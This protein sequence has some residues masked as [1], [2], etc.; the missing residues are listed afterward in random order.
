MARPRS[1]DAHAR[2]LAATSE[3]LE[4][5][6]VSELCIEEIAARAKVGK[7]TIYKWWA[8]KGELAMEAALANVE[9][10]VHVE[11]TGDTRRDLQSF[12]KKSARL[13]RET[14]TGR[15]L[16]AL[17]AQAQ[18]DPE[19]LEDFRERFLEVRRGALRTLLRGGLKTGQLRRD[20]DLELFIDLV[21]GAYWY[22]MLTRR[23]P[24]DDRFAAELLEMLWPFV[25]ARKKAAA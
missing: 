24:L 8:G 12:L 13:L 6:A 21:F 16:T 3:L 23:A 20:F 14:S 4:Q 5:T 15:T 9:A 1:S 18:G 25:A 11:D 10:H 17:M 22:R 2:I 19:F 7:Q